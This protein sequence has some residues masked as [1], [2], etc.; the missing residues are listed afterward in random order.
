MAR[1]T[2]FD[3]PG[4]GDRPFRFDAR[5]VEVF[6]DMIGRSVPGYAD[7]LETVRALA[8]AR[9]PEGGRCYDLGCSLGAATRVICSGMGARPGRVIAVDNSPAMIA[10]CEADPAFRGLTP[11]D[12][13]WAPLLADTVVESADLVVLNYTLQFVPPRRRRDVLARIFDGMRPGGVLV[14][15]EKFRFEN[16]EVQSLM[17][18]L[19]L[20]F[21]RRNGY[22]EMEIAGK[23]NALENVLIADSRE[24]H[25]ARLEDV[26][27][28]GVTLWQAQLNFGTVVAIRPRD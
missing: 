18:Q 28:R 16:P 12:D 2:L 21:K 3:K 13:A 20:D 24:R 7:S 1:D 14:L 23:R 5:V 17:T 9:V 8:E 11:G 10:R 19:H 26:G 4:S 27:F 25:V 15:S 6:E 22:S